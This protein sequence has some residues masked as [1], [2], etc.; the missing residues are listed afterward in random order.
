[1]EVLNRAVIATAFLDRLRYDSHEHCRRSYRLGEH[2]QAGLFGPEV[3]RG[4]KAN[5]DY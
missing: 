4:W 5:A 1:M 3:L 2:R